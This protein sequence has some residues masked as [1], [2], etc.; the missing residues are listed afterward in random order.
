MIADTPQ[1]P[2]FAVIFSSVLNPDREG[3][4]DMAARM[5]DLARTVDGFPG[6]ESARD[7]MGITV[8]N[9]SSMEAI[10]RWKSDREH[11]EAQRLGIEAWYEAFK[12]RVARVERDTAV[13]GERR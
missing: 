6:L 4:T 13:P 10:N 12:I 11:R 3:Y 2:F 5:E 8:S 1:P 9:W 7:T